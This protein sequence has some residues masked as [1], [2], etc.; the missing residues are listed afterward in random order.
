[1]SKQIK[2]IKGAE[3]D[4]P[5]SGKRVSAN[6]LRDLEKVFQSHFTKAA[7]ERQRCHIIACVIDDEGVTCWYHCV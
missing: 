5:K 1:M 6:Q 3:S 2:F 4:V 7:T